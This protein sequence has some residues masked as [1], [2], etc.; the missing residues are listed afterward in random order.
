MK[1]DSTIM[2]G[3]VPVDIEIEHNQQEIASEGSNGQASNSNEAEIVHPNTSEAAE[4]CDDIEPKSSSKKQGNVNRDVGETSKAGGAKRKRYHRHSDHQIRELEAF[5]KDCPHPD[6][7]QR[8]ELGCA[9]GLEPLQVK[10]WFQNK[11]T[12][13]KAQSERTTNFQL[14]AQNEKLR[15]ENMSFRHTL[16]SG[17]CPICGEQQVVPHSPL[18]AN[19]LRLENERLRAEIAR[20]TAFLAQF[21]GNEFANQN[22]IYP[23]PPPPVINV[24]EATAGED[25]EFGAFGGLGQPEVE[26]DLLFEEQPMPMPFSVPAAAPA[27]AHP[28]NDRRRI[29]DLASFGMSELNQMSSAGYPLWFPTNEHR[30]LLLNE[31]TYCEMFQKV[32]NVIRPPSSFKLEG[33]RHTE[34]VMMDSLHLVDVML[35]MDMFSAIFNSIVSK[36]DILDVIT[37]GHAGNYDYSLIVMAAEYQVLTPILPT[38]NS[39]FARYC[40]KLADDIWVVVDV[41]LDNKYSI[42][43]LTPNCHRMPSGCIIQAI[44]SGGSRVTWIEHVEV[45][46]GGVHPLV[47]PFVDSFLAFGAERWVSVLARQCERLAAVSVLNFPADDINNVV[48]KHILRLSECMVLSLCKGLT[49][50]TPFSWVNQS[51]GNGNCEIRFTTKTTQNNDPAGKPS[52]ILLSATTFFWLPLHHKLVFEFLSGE[53]TRKEWDVL[54]SKGK[55]QEFVHIT[56]GHEVGNFVSMFRVVNGENTGPELLFLQECSTDPTSSCIVYAPIESQA[57]RKLLV[58]ELAEKVELLP[59]GFTIYPSEKPSSLATIMNPPG[60][61]AGA[62]GS[63]V[64]LAFQLLVDPSNESSWFTINGSVTILTDLIESTVRR[65]KSALL[66]NFL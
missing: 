41:S 42:S 45:E 55:L 65:I 40:R 18:E 54:A 13:L 3:Q 26:G 27:A 31:G 37:G 29:I 59:S 33:T 47:K 4:T 43:P 20:A 35:D 17:C 56:T 50:S 38:R 62:A 9:L 34:I 61:S 36:V 16:A 63:L 48:R 21:G 10:F 53:N 64:T 49:S 58:G 11:R 24:G 19:N 28:T 14:K 60:D 12:Q 66:P 22:N 30:Q 57:A 8:K 32:A 25:N 15:A 5:F 46:D 51:A 6:D 52:S 7:R 23:N 2:I 39:V 1:R 44:P